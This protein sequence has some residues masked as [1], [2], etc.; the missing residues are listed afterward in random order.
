MNQP[1]RR[2]P[3]ASFFVGLWDVMNFT[4]RL[5]LNLVFFGFLLLLLLA[6]VF[7]M[8]RGDGAKALRD[9]TTLL[10]APEG[11][12]VEQ[13]SADPV[14]RALTK[15]MGDKGAEEIQLRDLIRALEAAK[16]DPKIERVALRLD[17]LQPSGFA[18]MREVSAALQ[19]LRAS[20]KQVVAYSDSLS[21]A[22]YLLAAQ[23][24]EV[25]LDP[26]GSV[27]LEGLGRYRQYF[28]EG[29]QD[30]L[31]VDVHLFKVG[32][33]K[34]A[35]EP[36]VLDAASPASKEADLFWMNDVWQR[37]VADIAKARKLAPEQI[38]AGIDTMP[39]GI[40]AAG[41]DM[42]K[43]AL[44]QKL[45]DGLKTREEVEE[46]LTKRG[47]ADDD[48]DT[49]FRN[50]NLDAYLQQ[51]DLR[52]SPV[53]SRPQ[54]AVVVA[55]GE[56]S[57]GEQPAGRIGGEST[58]ALLRDARDDEAVKAVVLR[59]DSPGGE[60]FASEQIRREVVALK[61]AGK[62]VVVSMGDL[63]ASGGYWI[64]MNA[65]RIYAD[66]STITGSIGI[67]GMIPNLTRSLDKIGVHTDG[68][69]TTRFAGAFDVT[70]PMDPVV[71]QVI[72]SVI[73]KGYADFTGK[74]AQAR[75]KPVEAIDQVARG[76]VWS[77][78]Q[79]KERGL[80]DA[81]GGFK[82]AVAD[83][84][85]RAK[86]GDRDKYR[87]RY[88]EKP[89]T[90]FAQFVNGFAGSRMGAWMLGDS[91]LAHAVLARSMPELDTQLRFVQDAT[92]KRDGTPVK[93]LAY[94]FCGF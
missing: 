5:I 28:R 69:G 31:G 45:V 81:F 74:V 46:L 20:G 59:V 53:D 13:F 26:M 25:Y 21:Q 91:A 71:G 79:A 33:F 54:V 86:L 85:A 64:S 57:G 10:I 1:V 51:L 49:G 55:A 66:P 52:H 72:Q 36:Y 16:T 90:P 92:D 89:A 61:A 2:S 24:N 93:A 23:A 19:D 73:N 77:G 32:E 4:R 82:D 12:L 41:G 43:F 70:R 42:A 14:S 67:F 83:A 50:V 17:K 62:P 80:V 9:R 35:A 75:N 87:V 47:V 27:V 18:S 22:Q 60:V 8:A 37:Y 56:I 40:A 6:I 29:L 68:V 48:A 3:I 44:Q 58:A 30:K 38:S 94:C 7:A 76:R 11:T 88:I 34:S 78:A 63:A 39:E 65:D 84:A 15:A